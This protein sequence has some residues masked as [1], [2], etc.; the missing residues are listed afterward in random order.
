MQRAGHQVLRTARTHRS[1]LLPHE[2]ASTSGV[3]WNTKRGMANPLNWVRERIIPRARQEVSR[4]EQEAARKRDEEKG[5]GSL[6]DAVPKL[7]KQQEKEAGE[8]HVVSKKVKVHTQHKYSTANF[9]ISHRKLNMLARQIAG[10]PID[11]AILQM[12]FSQ[13][14]AAKRIKSSL[15]L[16]RQH[17]VEYKGMDR[18]KLIIGQSW[19]T[20]G[21]KQLK[22]IEFKGRSKM[23]IRQHPDSRLSVI[24]HEGKT[25]E[26]KTRLLRERKLSKIRSPGLLREDKPLVNV[27]PVFAW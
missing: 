26:E 6:F 19:V 1:L 3:Q 10:K 24:L 2:I 13:K 18:S 14:R 7:I 15:V 27:P 25:L 9:K 16:A 11:H 20:K 4:Q 12:E 5:Q 8:Q 22:R 23:G 17:A 21:P